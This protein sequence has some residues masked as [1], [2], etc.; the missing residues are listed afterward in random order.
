[1][2]TGGWCCKNPCREC[3]NAVR[4]ISDF[5]V[6]RTFARTK[7]ELGRCDICGEKKA[8]YRS[9]EAQAKICEGCYARF[10]REWN[11]REGV[12]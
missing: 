3:W 6:H 1:M 11:G 12:R 10:V 8:V 9:R 5:P 2:E 4:K 7:V